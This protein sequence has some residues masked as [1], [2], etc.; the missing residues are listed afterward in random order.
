MPAE[1][2]HQSEM[3]RLAALKKRTEM[4]GGQKAI[5]KRHSLGK[6]TARERIDT[7]FDPGTFVEMNQLAE[8]QAVDFGMQ[9][10]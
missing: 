1:T 5:D 7:L 10:K 6:L 3:E 9:Q 4:G 8:S 2:T